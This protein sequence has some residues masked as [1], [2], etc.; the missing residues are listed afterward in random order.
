MRQKNRL[1]TIIGAALF[2]T[3]FAGLQSFKLKKEDKENPANNASV[4][5]LGTTKD[6]FVFRLVFW[7]EADNTKNPLAIKIF[8]NDEVEIFYQTFRD[9]RVERIFKVNIE[10]VNKLSFQL[11]NK[12]FNKEFGFVVNTLIKQEFMVKKQ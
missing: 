6:H 9:N 12:N 10:D 4:E 7:T 2:L 3:I 11:K 1:K 8:A 5:Y